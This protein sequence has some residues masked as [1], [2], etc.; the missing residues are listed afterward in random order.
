M[1]V[2]V[3]NMTCGHCKM[4]IENALKANGFDNVNIDLDSKMVEVELGSKSQS[5]VVEIIESKG[6]EVEL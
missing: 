3:T 2:E 5:D 1:K 6:Y 4:N